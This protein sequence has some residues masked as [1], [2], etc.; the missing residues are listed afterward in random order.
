MAG[1]Q[2]EQE[3]LIQVLADN[4]N[5]KDNTKVYKAGVKNGN[6]ETI[7]LIIGTAQH[8]L[9]AKTRYSP[10]LQLN[11]VRLVK[12]CFDLFVQEFMDLVA[13]QILPLMS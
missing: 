6:M 9:V 8:I 4:D 1:R 7:R 10:S 12:E 5:Y 3:K 13:E 2:Q 11:T